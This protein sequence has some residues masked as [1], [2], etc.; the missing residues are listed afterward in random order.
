ALDERAR[1][2][3]ALRTDLEVRAGALE[4]RR[5]LLAARRAE[6]RSRLERSGGTAE[7]AE[8][9][10][11]EL[12]RRATAVAGLA[13]S[14]AGHLAL[15]EESLGR[16]H[17]HRR[18]HR[19]AQRRAAARLD[20]LRSQR[21]ATERRLGEV[22]E[23]AQQAELEVAEVAVRLEAAV[24]GLRRELGVDGLLATGTPCPPL[25]EGVAATQRAEYL[26]RELRAMGPVNP[27]ALEELNELEERQRFV[28]D[29][30]EDVRASRRDLAKVI[31]AVDAEVSVTFA[32]A[33]ADVAAA[34]SDLIE[35]LFPGGGGAL[36]LT[37][38]GNLLDTGIE[39]EARPSGKS[40][41]RLSLLSGGERSLVALA[42]LF[43]VFRS[44]PSPFYLL[45]EVEAALDD[46]N[47][48][49]FLGLMDEFRASA[50][51]LVVTHQKRT[52]EA[53][54][55]LY[56]VSMAPGG[57]SKVLSERARATA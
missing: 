34:F 18:R 7:E 37:D 15:V 22:S 21:T 40:V 53:A 38:P 27:L 30:L 10:R 42:V 4:E 24:D 26:D 43:A 39:V 29:Q 9:R 54:D 45:D 55:C 2:L 12:E 56:G 47:L 35:L 17:E 23:Q 19:E 31:A 6:V 52:M 41:R 5:S 16:L 11:A 20:D 48:H 51:L 36:R 50:Q 28:E 44:R 1:A 49:R 13:A 25:P 14:V 57:S 3:A 8:A 32:A 46:V 33:Y